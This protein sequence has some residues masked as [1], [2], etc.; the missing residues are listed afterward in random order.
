[1]EEA[2]K[3]LKITPAWSFACR[4]QRLFTALDKSLQ[5]DIIG[6]TEQ[7]LGPC[8]AGNHVPDPQGP[9]PSSDYLNTETG[10]TD[11]LRQKL[12]DFNIN[13]RE[14]GL[15]GLVFDIQKFATHEGG[16]IRP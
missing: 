9:A 1:M 14:T 2:R 15:M 8:L 5:D 13:K 11:E 3:N 4:L 16:G 7:F 6:R 10:V 12:L